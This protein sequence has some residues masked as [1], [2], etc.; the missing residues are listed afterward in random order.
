MFLIIGEAGI[1]HASGHFRQLCVC[2]AAVSRKECHVSAHYLSHVHSVSG[3]H[4]PGVYHADEVAHDR[5]LSR[6]DPCYRHDRDSKLNHA[7]V[8]QLPQYSE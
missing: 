7:P 2:E 3:H 1:Y 4:D 5:Y 8:V 6:T